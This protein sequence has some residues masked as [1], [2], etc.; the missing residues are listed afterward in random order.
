[1]SIYVTIIFYSFL[2]FLY[3]A[4]FIFLPAVKN[5]QHHINRPFARLGQPIGINLMM[6]NG[7][8]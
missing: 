8:L 4:I 6:G 1:M 7:G 5:I 2:D 3:I